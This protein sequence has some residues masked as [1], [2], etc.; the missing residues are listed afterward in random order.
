MVMVRYS[1]SWIS[2]LAWVF[3]PNYDW[4]FGYSLS[5]RTLK[6]CAEFTILL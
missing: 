4:L 5:S 3:A 6:A 1:S 2:A